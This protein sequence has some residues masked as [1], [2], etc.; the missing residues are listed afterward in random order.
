L[1]ILIFGAT[2]GTGLQLVEQALQRGHH[3]TAFVRD[4]AR[5]ALSNP[6]LRVV[7]GNVMSAPDVDAV[8]PG[9]D[10]VLCALGTMPEAKADRVRRQPGVRVCS[11][12][13]RNIV[14]AMSRHKV[15]RIV[16]ESSASVGESRHTG[17]FAASLVLWLFLRK[18]MEDKER[19]EVAV[20]QSALDFTIVRPPKLT[21][22]PRKAKLHA[23]EDLRW[24]LRD[25][26]SR[27]DVAAC[28]LDAIAD[29]STVRRAMTV[30]E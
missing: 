14:H 21:F 11:E 20:M 10:A 6:A 26:A 15:R 3:V 24:G 16:V 1:N 5:L 13:T 2:G 29:A 28:M 9:Q 25:T 22:G 23:G 30:L 7:T 18:V 4:P 8:I 27:A 17:K 12:G 19:Q